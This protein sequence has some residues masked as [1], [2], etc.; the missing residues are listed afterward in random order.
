MI[1]PK[2]NGNECYAGD[3][4][5]AY[6]RLNE[7]ECNYMCYKQGNLPENQTCGGKVKNSIWDIS[8]YN[9]GGEFAFESGH[10]KRSD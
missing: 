8:M 10:C 4:Y 6:G 1:R 5:G 3:N 9:G 2:Q 7:Y